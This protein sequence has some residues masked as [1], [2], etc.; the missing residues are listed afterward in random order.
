VLNHTSLQRCFDEVQQTA[1]IID[2][3]GK[4][5]YGLHALRHFFASWRIERGTESKR[6]QQLM[7]YGSIKMTYDTY[8]HWIGEVADEH[9][10]L[11]DDEAA[12]LGMLHRS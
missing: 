10:R 11:A 5:K 7:G 3:A 12:V 9:A 8:G 2:V 6:L 4:S 1:G